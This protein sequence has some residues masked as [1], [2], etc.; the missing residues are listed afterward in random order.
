M[1]GVPVLQTVELMSPKAPYLSSLR[2][3]S[4]NFIS[5]PLYLILITILLWG[6]DLRRLM[7]LGAVLGVARCPDCDGP[8]LFPLLIIAFFVQ[9]QMHG[10]DAKNN[11]QASASSRGFFRRILDHSLVDLISMYSKTYVFR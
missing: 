6:Q 9:R 2:E 8:P 4:D 1:I 5:Y 3:K 11:S 7:Q 10:R